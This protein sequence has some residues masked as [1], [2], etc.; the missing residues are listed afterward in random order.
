MFL[1]VAAHLKM[2]TIV[3]RRLVCG[4]LLAWRMVEPANLC[5]A[6]DTEKGFKM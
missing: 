5:T 3:L 6:V 4:F 2:E 1:P